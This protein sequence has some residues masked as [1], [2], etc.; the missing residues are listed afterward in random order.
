MIVLYARV[1]TV[2]QTTEHQLTQATQAGFKIDKVVADNGV[3]G[4]AFASPSAAR[5]AGCSICSGPATR[6]WCA[7]SIGLAE[8]R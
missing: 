3:S 4:S 8:L 1:S 7:G 2:E 5:A 6:S